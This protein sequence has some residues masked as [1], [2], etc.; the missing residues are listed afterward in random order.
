MS[1]KEALEDGII[2]EK[3]GSGSTWYFPPCHVCGSAVPSW[4]YMR[5]VKY[6]CPDCKKFLAEIAVQQKGE[7]QKDRKYREAIKRIGKVARLEPYEFAMKQVSSQLNKPGWYQSTEEIMVA[8]ELI[9]RNVTAYH[10]VKVLGCCVDFMLP[11]FK[12]V[13]EIDGTIFHSKEK[14]PSEALRDELICQALGDGW[15]VI[16]I[17]TENINTNVTKLIP[18]IKKVLKHRMIS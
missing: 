11:Q 6:T 8:L 13:L 18:A 4:N 12:V 10:Q 14:K 16:R 3:D 1:Y 2:R 7:N 5:G 17:R 15:Q 9:R